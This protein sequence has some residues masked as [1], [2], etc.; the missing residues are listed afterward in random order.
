MDNIGWFVLAAAGMGLFFFLLL[1]LIMWRPR[2][3]QPNPIDEMETAVGILDLADNASRRKA[4]PQDHLKAFAVAA[5]YAM[6]V[7]N[8]NGGGRKAQPAP[9]PQPPPQTAQ[10]G[11]QHHMVIDVNVNVTA[12]APQPPP[13]QT[14]GGGS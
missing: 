6:N 1:L 2:E 13:Q 4:A 12:P 11:G 10:Q 3:E 8:R 14:T 5:N 7:I 9:A